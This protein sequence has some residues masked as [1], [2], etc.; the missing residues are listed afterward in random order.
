MKRTILSGPMGNGRTVRALAAAIM[1]GLL[2]TTLT[3]ILAPA[4]MAETVTLKIATL[5]PEGSFWMDK[6][7]TGADEVKKK[8]GD[9]VII[10]YYPG[11]VMGDDRAVLRKIR[12]GQLQ[13]GAVVAGS[14]ATVYPD[15][16]L[17][18]MPLKFRSVEEV[19]YVRQR[20][21][22]VMVEG[23][24]KGGFIALGMAEGGFAYIMSN[25]PVLSVADMGQRKVW[26]PDNDPTIL[27]GVRAFDINPIPLSLADVRAGL[28]TGLIDTVT[29][30]PIGAVAFQWHTQVKVITDMPFL[31]LFAVLAVDKDAFAKIDAADQ[32]LVREIMGRVF[33]EIEVQNRK[34]NIGALAALKNQGITF[35]TPGETELVEWKRRASTVPAR[36]V[37]TSRFSAELVQRLDA[38]LAEYRSAT[39]PAKAQ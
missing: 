22:P 20:I 28:Q 12:I 14:L 35:V 19:D 8:T 3:T 31:Y 1:T 4:A 32:P 18:G 16:Q 7:R 30:S 24:D 6:M 25:A 11:G 34:D 36:L 5:S 38:L 13:G 17:Y 2:V 23:L 15:M 27:E 39:P 37:E 10:K 21:D 33:K 29:T 9:R 26:I